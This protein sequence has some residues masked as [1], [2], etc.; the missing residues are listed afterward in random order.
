MICI[1]TCGIE[2]FLL[3]ISQFV[4]YIHAETLLSVLISENSLH[5][6]YRKLGLE[7]QRF[8]NRRAI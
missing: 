4:A 5:L 1:G 2:T 8:Q 3:H 6:F 7:M